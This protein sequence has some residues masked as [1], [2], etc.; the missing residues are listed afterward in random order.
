MLFFEAGDMLFQNVFNLHGD[1]ALIFFG[2]DLG[3]GAVAEAEKIFWGMT[4][5]GRGEGLEFMEVNIAI[6]RIIDDRS[7]FINR[8]G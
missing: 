6:C 8:F 1:R 3:F 4:G 2:N 7:R 5:C